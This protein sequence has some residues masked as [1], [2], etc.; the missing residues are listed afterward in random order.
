MKRSTFVTIASV[1][2][3]VPMLLL[4]ISIKENKAEQQAINAVP[5]IKKLEPKSAEWG[6]YYPRQ[7]DSYLE[8]RKSDEIKDVLK[9]DPN[10]V[11]LWAGYGFS[12]DYNAPRGHYYILEDNINTLRT[13]APIDQKS[14]PMPTAC[15]TCKSPDVPRLIEEKGELDFFTG[16]WARWGSEIVNPIGCADCHDNETMK[17]TVT[18]DFLKRALDA[19]GSEPFAEAKHQD[20]RT[21]VCVQCHSEYYFKKTPWTDPAGEEHTAGVVTFPWDNGLSAEDIEQYYDE[22]EFVDWTHKL[23]KTPMLKAQHPGYETFKTGI[24]GKNNLACADCHMPYVREGGVKYS[25]HKI[26]SPLDDMQNTCLN[27]HGE[28]EQELKDI[29]ARKLERKNELAHTATDILAKAHLEAAKAWELGATEAEMKPALTDIRHGQWRWDFA[30]AAHG[31]FFHAPEETLRIL[32]SAI[33]KAHD[34]RLK[35]RIILAKYSAADYQAPAITSKEQA[36]ELIGLPMEKLV[37]DKKKFL[38]TLR[39]EWNKEAATK[40]IFDPKTRDMEFKTS[41]SK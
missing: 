2:I 28:S 7:Y 31:G 6:K 21:L 23:S 27:C 39:E 19:E 34:A 30:V 29:I 3:M 26:G 22:R 18:R 36:Q 40:G 14:G 5:E 17:L 9:Q 13:G 20:M 16:K 8:T 4:V 38:G 11:V 24:H 33:N 25:S 12:K 41:Y 1:V 10:L 35:L 32:G 15:W 37:S